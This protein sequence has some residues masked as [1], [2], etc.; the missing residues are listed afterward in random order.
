[1][2]ITSTGFFIPLEWWLAICIFHVDGAVICEIYT[3][4][5][6]YRFRHTKRDYLLFAIATAYDKNLF[7]DEDLEPFL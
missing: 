3:P 5:M 2:P 4:L 7:D 6:N 1:M